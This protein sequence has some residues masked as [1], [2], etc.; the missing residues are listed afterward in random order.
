M[1][2]A[3]F[4]AALG[5]TACAAPVKTAAAQ[6]AVLINPSAQ[7]TAQMEHA[8]QT[9]LG[10]PARIA[11]NVLVK[12][13]MLNIDPPFNDRSLAKPDRF[14]L[15]MRGASCELRHRETGKTYAIKSAR[16]KAY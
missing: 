5:L 14:Y 9:A 3:L 16:C 4:T 15:Q 8:V 6:N 7:V 12:D 11:P 2:A 10:R 1:K 13:N